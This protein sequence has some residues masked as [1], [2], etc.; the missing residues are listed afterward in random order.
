MARTSEQLLD[1]A[2]AVLR[3]G[4][5][6]T[7]ESVAAEAGMSKAGVVHHFAS[8]EA[9]M[10]GVVDRVVDLWEARLADLAG[11]SE[12]PLARLR[13]YV[14]FG[15]TGVFDGADLALLADVKLRD[16]LAARWRERLQPWFGIEAP[17]SAEQKAS[18]QAA[19]LIADGAWTDQALGLLTMT[20]AERERVR[21]VAQR[22]IDAGE[23]R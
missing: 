10:L 2:I 16:V 9:L 8:K 15:V 17:G 4:G 20:P 18:L 12:D 13:A 7:I 11:R 5:V 22:L 1:D 3:R 19:R 21:G 23:Q 14:D 6:V